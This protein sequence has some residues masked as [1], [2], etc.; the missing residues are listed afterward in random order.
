MDEIRKLA[1]SVLEI[2]PEAIPEYF[3]ARLSDELRN[4][5]KIPGEGAVY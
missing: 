3:S 1:E 4:F 2:S 5:K